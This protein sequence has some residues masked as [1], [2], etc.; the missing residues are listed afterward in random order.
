MKTTCHVLI[1]SL[2]CLSFS[3]NASAADPVPEKALKELKFMAGK[4]QT[5]LTEGGEKVGTTHH[6]RKWAPGKHCLIMTSRAVR[7]GVETHATGISGWNAKGKAIVEHWYVSDGLSGTVRYPLAK[8]TE[9]AWVGTH[10]FI[11]ADGTEMKG[12]CRLEKKGPDEWVFTADWE[13]DGKVLTMK[14]FTRKVKE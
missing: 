14:N 8:M 11:A 9:D 5:D 4:W 3:S 7:N 13:E 1:A 12:K 2:V 6:E 10:R